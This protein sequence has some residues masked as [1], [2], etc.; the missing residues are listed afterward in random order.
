MGHH[1][2]RWEHVMRVR[3]RNKGIA[4]GRSRTAGRRTSR[5]REPWIRRE[6]PARHDPRQGRHRHPDRPTRVVQ[7]VLDQLRPGVH[8][9]VRHEE[10][11]A[12]DAQRCGV[13]QRLPRPHGVGDRDLPQRDDQRPAAQAHGVVRRVVP[14]HRERAQRPRR[15]PPRHRVDVGHSVRRPDH[16]PRATPSSPTTCTRSSPGRSWPPSAR[17][18]TRCTPWAAPVP[19]CGS[20][21]AAAW[22]TATAMP[23]PSTTTWREPAGVNVPGVHRRP[24]LQPLLRRRGPR[25]RLRHPPRHRRPGCTRS[26]ATATSPAPTRPPPTGSATTVATSGSPT[27]PSR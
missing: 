26:R 24:G 7:I 14:R 21:S 8:R 16:P 6:R 10:R 19:T 2:R 9:R 5:R 25:P 18:T 3:N 12:A 22:P 4:G 11:E 1:H 13:P 27:Q 15:Q 23:Y 20:R 17:R